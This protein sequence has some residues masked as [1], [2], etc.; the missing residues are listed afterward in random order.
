MS[1]GRRPWSVHC[2]RCRRRDWHVPLQVVTAPC[3]CCHP[4]PEIQH[5]EQGYSPAHDSYCQNARPCRV[6]TPRGRLL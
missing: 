4:G 5:S 2:G 3:Y 1:W 6:G